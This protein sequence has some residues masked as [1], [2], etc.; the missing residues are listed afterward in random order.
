MLHLHPWL[1][2]QAFRIGCLDGA[3]GRIVRPQGVWAATGAEI[4]DWYGSDRPVSP[5]RP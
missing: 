3:L 4:I 5:A 2:G 1:I